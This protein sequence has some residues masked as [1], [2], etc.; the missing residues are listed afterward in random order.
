MVSTF[1]CSP[2]SPLRFITVVVFLC[3]VYPVREQSRLCFAKLN[4][5]LVRIR[6]IGQWPGVVQSLIL[7]AARGQD[8]Q[9]SLV[10]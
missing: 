10:K 2:L 9:G 8:T 1:L 3:A 6:V 5:L 4:I 7:L